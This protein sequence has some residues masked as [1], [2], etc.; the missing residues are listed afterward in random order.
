MNKALS[1]DG[2]PIAYDRTGQGRP[3]IMVDGAMCSRSFGPG[4]SLAPLLSQHFT[5]FVY[6]RRGRNDSGNT[7]PYG[8]AREVEDIAALIKVAGEPVYLF[9]HSSGGALA[10]E[11]AA[12]GLK[13]EKVAVYEP[14]YVASGNGPLPARDAASEL[15]RLASTSHRGDAIEYFMVQMMGQPAA[16]VAQMRSAPF[17]PGLEAI[18]HTL[19][20][21][22]TIMGNWLVPARFSAITI[23]ALVMDGSSS[24]AYMRQAAQ[25]LAKTL[26]H[27][28]Y[29]SLEGQM[30][31]VAAEVIAPLLIEFFTGEKTVVRP[32]AGQASRERRNP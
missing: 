9:G 27:A 20:Y 4:M 28:Q 30:H 11:A 29:R 3:A 19:A 32:K 10:L 31:N 15:A 7:L 25:A 14:P 5:V 24:P 21:E 1:K 18:A 16:Q 22:T 23:P 26:P 8:V 13:V 2:T 6:D 12:S 17:W